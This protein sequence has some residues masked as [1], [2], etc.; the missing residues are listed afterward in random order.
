MSDNLNI[1]SADWLIIEAYC[2]NQIAELHK[3]NEADLDAVE[4]ATIRG[5][6]KMARLI[7]DLAVEDVPIE[8][9]RSNNYIE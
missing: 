6:L 9:V 3:E 5:Q 2:E 1:H 8:M 4:T 7:L